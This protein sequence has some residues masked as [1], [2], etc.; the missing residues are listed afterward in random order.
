[1][2]M[3]GGGGSGA[4]GGGCGGGEVIALKVDAHA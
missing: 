4:Y 3:T 2:T 1:M